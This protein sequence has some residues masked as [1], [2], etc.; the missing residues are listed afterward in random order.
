MQ[1][2]K[3]INVQQHGRRARAAGSPGP[4]HSE[5]A[6]DF[7]QR[8]TGQTPGQARQA[9]EGKGHKEGVALSACRA[10]LSIYLHIVTKDRGETRPDIAT[11]LKAPSLA[12]QRPATGWLAGREGGL[13]SL[14]ALDGQGKRVLSLPPVEVFV[15]GGS[16]IAL[17]CIAGEQCPKG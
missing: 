14:R 6:K 8:G 13:E 17:H 7:G 4:V 12:S 9:R 16:A 5:Q 10:C 3:S 1:R 2:K 15:G 11:K